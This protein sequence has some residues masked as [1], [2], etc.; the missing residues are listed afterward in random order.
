MDQDQ[1]KMIILNAIV[2]CEDEDSGRADVP[3]V[4]AAKRL[5]D[6]IFAA[7]SASD[8]LKTEDDSAG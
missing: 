5:R 3:S 4:P 8:L 6:K 1:I 2:N 7:L